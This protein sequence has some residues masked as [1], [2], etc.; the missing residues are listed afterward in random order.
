MR[1]K[2]GQLDAM[3]THTYTAYNT[4]VHQS[5]IPSDMMSDCL[6]AIPQTADGRVVNRNKRKKAYTAP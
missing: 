6:K 2:I 5:Y 4:R 1:T 3:P